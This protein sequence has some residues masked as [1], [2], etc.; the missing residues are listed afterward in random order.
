[1][2]SS[3]RLA[4]AAGPLLVL[5]Y[6]VINSTKSVFEGALVQN[7]S[8]EFIA[9]NSFVVA[10]AFYFFTLRDKGQ[11]KDVIRRCLP[12]VVMLNVSTAV[13]W[14]AV[15]YA[16]TVFEPAMANSVIIG[17][18][19]AV[20]IV[21]GFKL[22]PGT[23]ALPLELAAAG[24]MI[25]A[26]AYLVVTASSGDSA[27]GDVPTGKLVFGIVM[28]VLTTISLSGVTYYTKRLGDAGMSVRQ[29]MASRFVVLI[30]ATFVILVVRG[31]FGAYSLGN[32]GAILA[33]SLVGVIISLYLL[34]Q[35]IVRTEPIT[36]SM[37]FGTNLVITYIVQFV[38]PRLHQSQD[39]LYGVLAISLAM[40][41]GTWARWRAGRRDADEP[42]QDVT[43]QAEAKA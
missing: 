27:I 5:G 7:L 41:L 37:L 14:I 20:T 30:V 15:L 1:M 13:C 24:G 33:I 19:P 25:V 6:C 18:G 16:F 29:M 43:A 11:L 3:R 17:L 34:Q 39:T 21:L 26:M 22:R 40:C 28:C 31:S 10:Q 9:F 4:L 12:D 38:D 42:G 36:V 2:S 35:G 8:P 23:K 32:V